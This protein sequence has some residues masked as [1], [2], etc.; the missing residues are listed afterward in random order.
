MPEIWGCG[1]STS[2]AYT[3]AFTV[4]H[5]PRHQHCTDEAQMAETLLP[6]VSY[7]FIYLFISVIS[8]QNFLNIKKQGLI[9]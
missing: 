9:K 2:A 8:V 3:R 4:V 6:V 5:F 1:L 7:I